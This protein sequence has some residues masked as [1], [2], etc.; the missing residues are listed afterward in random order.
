MVLLVGGRFDNGKNSFPYYVDNTL[1]KASHDVAEITYAVKVNG[2]GVY[3][4]LK[5]KNIKG[6]IPLMI[7]IGLQLQ[8][9]I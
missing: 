5:V 7:K 8:N 1:A 6:K 4:K 2:N 9:Q 3:V